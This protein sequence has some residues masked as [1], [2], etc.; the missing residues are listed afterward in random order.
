MNRLGKIFLVFLLVITLTVP[1]FQG[2]F[3]AFAA[4]PDGQAGTDITILNMPSE[5]TIGTTIE[6]PAGSSTNGTIVVEVLDPRG[7]IV[8]DT[9]GST[10][11]ALNPNNTYDLDPLLVG[12]Y[13]VS[14]TSVSATE[15]TLP[16]TTCPD[17]IISV[18]GTNPYF[19]FDINSS[20][21]L[22]E[23]INYDYQIV[24][25]YPVVYGSDGEVDET[26]TFTISGK[27]PDSVTA[28]TFETV[29]I[30]S[31]SY[32][33]FTPIAADGEGI[34][35]LNYSYSDGTT[36][37]QVNETFEVVVDSDFSE[38]DIELNYSLNG[39]MPTTAVLGIEVELPEPITR[40][41]NSNNALINTYTEVTVEWIDEDDENNNI[42]YVVNDFS[43]T[44]LNEGTYLVTYKIYDF[45]GNLNDEVL[46]EYTYSIVDVEDT[47]APEVMVVTAYD[48]SVMDSDSYDFEDVSAYI[49]TNVA[50]GTVVQ[51]PA[52][53]ATDNMTLS[54]ELTYQRIM[55][56][57]L[58]VQ[59]DIDFEVNGAPEEG[60]TYNFNQAVPYLFD[61]AGTYT[62]RYMA[63]DES[64]NDEYISYIVNVVDGFIDN[65]APRITIETLPSYVETGEVIKFVK[66]TAVDYV[67]ETS[68][69]TVDTRVAVNVYY[70]LGDDTSSK[71]EILEDEDDSDY[72]S[73]IIPSSVPAGYLHVYVEAIDDGKNNSAQ[74]N[75]ATKIRKLNIMDVND[76][77]A[78]IFVGDEPTLIAVDQDTL[79]T[80]PDV[81]FSDDNPTYISIDANIIDPNGNN[82]YLSGLQMEYEEDTLAPGDA[83]GIVVSNAK[84]TATLAGYYNIIF[85]IKDVAGNIF[86]KSYTQYVSDTRAPSFQLD[87][88]PV[89]VEVGEEISLPTPTIMDN[90][91]EIENQ[92]TTTVIFI[93][94]PSY[95]FVLAS[96]KFTP[97][98]EG[99]YSFKFIAEDESGNVS[100]SAV[101]TVTSVD[102]IDPVLNIDQTMIFPLTAPLTRATENDPFD[103]I[104]IPGFMPYDNLNGIQ[105]YYV[106]V[107]NPDG[108][109]ILDARDAD[110]INGSNG[111]YQFVPT[112]AG[113][114]IVS[115]V[116]LD[117]SGNENI[118]IMVAKVGD[119]AA[120]VL[121]IGN[122]TVNMPTSKELNSVLTIDTTTITILDNEDNT[123]DLDD[124]TTTGESKFTI[125]LTAPSGYQVDDIVDVD[126]SY[127]LTEVGEYTITYTA[128]DEAGNEQV[129]TV[130]FQVAAS[131][132]LISTITESWGIVLIILSLLVLGGVIV[133][134]M[135]SKQL[136]ED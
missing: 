49:P 45:F 133:Y 52:I 7:D 104:E 65:Q 36:G 42:D 108:E 60:E 18:T 46:A 28:I 66:P 72:L 55:L 88:I 102:S 5:G 96:H 117:N 126:Y 21:M 110:G 130:I 121:T 86:V 9:A 77:T 32:K 113:S 56:N 35:T 128:R 16:S 4:D 11:P 30:D 44:P 131:T 78:P 109:V 57:N 116:A 127:N 105:E 68:T 24:L 69:S 73:F 54:S 63:T 3:V 76:T 119:N 79:V 37:L 100:Q 134:F 89:T 135:K 13:V 70:Y 92:A 101:Y 34:Y 98:E 115:Y 62:I 26:P 41:S 8:I 71:V 107:K 95:E 114:Y 91:V 120:P 20:I 40:D 14:Y 132:S 53:H 61:T 58:N 2:A 6:I 82:V 25:P 111:N 106:E 38:D 48:E 118:Q 17:Y 67:D 12:D 29:V 125:S 15:A 27:K 80:I 87:S 10:P 75:T 19:D 47:Q 64:G 74:V 85:A 129:E 23:T 51:L 99:I 103:A 136:V 59:I 122:S 93:D 112:K 22:P 31:V 97:L 94:C 123:I 1:S 33:T 90:G 50:T 43:F 84:F 81:K 124:T 83:D 39:S